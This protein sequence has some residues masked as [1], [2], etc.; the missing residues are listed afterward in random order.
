M[1][2]LP[3]WVGIA[4]TLSAT[5]F[6]S[7]SAQADL[8]DLE[9]AHVA[10]T[11]NNTDIAYA[12]LALA[13]SENPAIREFAEAMIRDHTAVTAQ[14]VAL[15]ER[16]NVQAQDNDLS[17]QM[18]ANAERIKN[19]L[20]ELRG[21]DFDRFYAENELRYHQTVNGIVEDAFIPNIDHPEVKRAFQ[22]ALAL[23]RGHERHAERM[24][25]QVMADR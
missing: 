15:A 7:L 10:V 22:Q 14:V 6:A 20:S 12:H 25:N 17:R 18:R 11:A 4:V 24:V 19:Q 8:N 2:C 21:A 16:L 23:F 3:M 5:P 13:L 1:K 9:M